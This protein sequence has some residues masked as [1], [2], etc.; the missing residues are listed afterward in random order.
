[1]PNKNKTRQVYEIKLRALEPA[2]IDL[3]YKWENDPEIWR[4]SNTYTPFSRYVLEKYI[5]YS[6]LDLY[7]VKQLRLMI[8]IF[9]TDRKKKRSIGSVDL[10][11]FDPYHNRAG[12]GILIGEKSYRKKGYASA[13]LGKMIDYGFNV[14]QL[15]QIYCNIIP[16]NSESLGLF[17]KYGFRV[18]G[19]KKDW[20]KTP[21]RYVEEYMLQLINP[22]DLLVI[23]KP[24]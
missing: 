4:V 9:D 14:L 13:A 24:D 22:N 21:G 1:M 6:H 7:Q 16:E 19:K 8:D 10:F 3:L 18:C 23:N 12:V 17:K 11:N 2:D 20:I 5:E 15:H